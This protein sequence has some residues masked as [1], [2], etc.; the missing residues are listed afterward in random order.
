MEW[1]EVQGRIWCCELCRGHERV[2]CDIRQRTEPPNRSVKL[3]L[4]G[5]APPHV[6]DITTK[7]AASSATNDEDDNLRKLF[8][9]ATLGLPWGDLLGRG[10]FLVHGVKCAIVPKDR[11][12]DPPDDVVDV[13]APLHFADELRLTRPLRIVAFGGAPHRALAKVPEITLPKGL[14]VSKRVGELVAKTRGGVELQ[15]GGWT[16]RLHVSPFPLNGKK[17]NPVAAEVLREA[18]RLSGLVP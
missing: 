1:N 17:P 2:A 4:I 3:M 10:L 16:S 15:A 8:V 5:V 14:G 12:Q 7:A 6:K 11:H 9:V 13:C 18:A